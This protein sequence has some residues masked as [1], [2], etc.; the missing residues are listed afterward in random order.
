[1]NLPDCITIEEPTPGYPVYAIH[2]PAAT[3]RVALHGAHL[4]EWTPAGHAPVLFM[5][6]QA[7]LEAGKPVR[8]GIPICWPW[9]GGHPNDATK[10]MHGIARI[11]FWHLTEATASAAGVTLTFSLTSDAQTLAA[12]PHAFAARVEM[13]IGQALEVRLSTQNLG[14]AP[15]SITEALHTYLS[16]GDIDQV[17]VRG[18]AGLAYLDTVGPL[19]MRQQEG[20]IV[21]DREV[22][23]QYVSTGPVVVADAALK[24]KVRIENEGSNTVVVWNPWIEKSTRL[25]D[26]P[27]HDYPRFLCIE[28][29]NT[30]DTAPT[31]QPGAMHA[32][33]TRLRVS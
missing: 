23:R 2:H 31:V 29:A 12:W 15:F 33:L 13:R 21:I 4:M 32:I 27:N 1:M 24:R 22:D 28:A 19:T 10:P 16:V 9:F 26:L 20:D 14:Q 6:P 7:V 11:R 3:A 17:T 18:L 25:A 30:G 5:S 8:G